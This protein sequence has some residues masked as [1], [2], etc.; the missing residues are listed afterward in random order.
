M[1]QTIALAPYNLFQEALNIVQRFS[2]TFLTEYPAINEFIAYIEKTWL[3]L[4]QKVSVYGCSNRTNNLVES[5]YSN[6]T[7]QLRFTS[8]HLWKF[9]GWFIF[10]FTTMILFYNVYYIIQYFT[11]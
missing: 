1:A 3:P 2:I 9:L 8:S 6:I 7:K 10:L 11:I 5:F 4:A